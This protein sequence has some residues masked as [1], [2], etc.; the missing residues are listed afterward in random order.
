MRKPREQEKAM[1][2]TL[3]LLGPHFLWSERRVPLPEVLGT[4]LAVTASAAVG[5][6]RGWSGR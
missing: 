4:C 5:L 3:L 1:G 2:I 6:L